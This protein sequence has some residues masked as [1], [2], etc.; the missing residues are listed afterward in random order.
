MP[1]FVIGLNHNTAP[2]NLRE[3]LALNED[4]VRALCANPR[5]G[6]DCPVS[7]A[8]VLS[9]CN[10]TELYA[11]SSDTGFDSL[12]GY[13]SDATNVPVA[14]FRL[15]L[16][17]LAGADAVRHLLRVAA[18]LDSLVLGEPQILGQVTRA[19]ALARSLGTSGPLLSRLFQAAI[20]SGKRVHS[21]TAIG[22]NP[23]SVASLAAS[24]AERTVTD[25][26]TA[27]VAILGA[28]EMAELT[29][30][31]LRK[32]GASRITLINR[33][34]ERVHALAERWA[35]GA[36]PFEQLEESLGEADILITSTS[37]D[38][39]LISRQMIENVMHARPERPLL[40]ID[41]AVPRNIDPAAAAVPNVALYDID[42][43]NTRLE[44]SLAARL[45][46]VP[47]AEQIVSEE[48]AKFLE[49]LNILN[50]MP[51]IADLHQQAENI[52]EA[53]LAKTLRHLPNLTDAEREHLEALTRA[54]VSKLLSEPTKRLRIEAASPDSQHYAETARTLFGLK[55]N[56]SSTKH[57]KKSHEEKL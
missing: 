41:I 51:V 36:A 21:E 20:H 35:A 25:I 1:I 55:E 12:E 53:E 44:Q 14:L 19:F 26:A 50:M 27:Q 22:R 13:L 47:H 45:A 2:L 9:T 3:R 39:I 28:G 46:E 52:R 5:P 33:S 16:Y 29:V 48:T 6:S 18:G 57:T 38:S 10:R 31:A 40:L 43:L 42:H 8:I 11:V 17:R 37:A 32:R 24:I 56:H 30:E 7:E 54:L 4:S 49:F 23:A 34:R 15:H